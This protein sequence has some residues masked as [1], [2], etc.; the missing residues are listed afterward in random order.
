M[1]VAANKVLSQAPHALGK[2]F[3]MLL[4]RGRSQRPG[5]GKDQLYVNVEDNAGWWSV[6]AL[7]RLL[8][9]GVGLRR[10]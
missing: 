6:V 5:K 9:G 7:C 10:F 3:R 4:K 2:V 8:I 1:L